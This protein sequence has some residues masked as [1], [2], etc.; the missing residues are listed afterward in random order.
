[1]KDK[2][3]KD[4]KSLILMG[5][6]LCLI[7]ILVIGGVIT[8]NSINT[9][10]NR[11][12]APANANFSDD[13]LY[14][15]VVDAYNEENDASMSY[16]TN[17]TDA[18]L[19][20][21]TKLEC[22]NAGVS[23]VRGLNKLSNLKELDLANNNITYFGGESSTFSS[24]SGLK[25]LV[26]D[27]NKLDGAGQIYMMKGD[28]E[29][30]SLKNNS[31]SS[32]GAWT[33]PSLV[34]MSKLKYLNV[35]NNEFSTMNLTQ[36]TNLEELDA[37][38]NQLK[39]ID[40]SNNNNL[41]P[42][43]VDISGN[44]FE[45]DNYVI[46]DGAAHSGVLVSSVT[47]PSSWTISTS[48]YYNVWRVS[49]TLPD[50][51]VASLSNGPSGYRI[52]PKGIGNATAT[53]TAANNAFT[54]KCNVHS[55]DVA[56]DNE[57]YAT[58]GSKYIWVGSDATKTEEQI[59]SNLS[60]RNNNSNDVEYHFS[61][62]SDVINDEVK[63]SLEYNGNVFAEV[64]VYGGVSTSE[65]YD[66]D[67]DYI[68]F[69][70]EPIK[71]SGDSSTKPVTISKGL[72]VFTSNG[73]V[74]IRNTNAIVKRYVEVDY[75]SSKYD[76][77]VDEDYIW[78]GADNI[79]TANVN[80]TTSKQKCYFIYNNNDAI[81]TLYY[82]KIDSQSIDP[83]SDP[84]IKTWDI[85]GWS[86]DKYDYVESNIEGYDFLVNTK[87]DSSIDSN[88][89]IENIRVTNGTVSRKPA[90]LNYPG[91]YPDDF[92]IKANKDNKIIKE[93]HTVSFYSDKYSSYLNKDYIDV[94]SDEL[95]VDDFSTSV[96]GSVYFKIK[97]NILYVDDDEGEGSTY[98]QWDI[99]SY[100]S[101]KYDLDG[102]YIFVGADD[103]IETITSNITSTNIDIVKNDYNQLEFRHGDEVIKTMDIV[104]CDSS[105]Y[106]LSKKYIFTGTMS[107]EFIKSKIDYDDANSS[108]DIEGDNL[109]L[110]PSN[111]DQPIKTWKLVRCVT[112]GY[113][114]GKSY[115]IQKPT[116][117]ASDIEVINGSYGGVNRGY[118][119]ISYNGET[120]EVPVIN[121]VS[122]NNKYDLEKTFTGNHDSYIYVGT[123][124]LDTSNIRLWFQ[125]YTDVTEQLADTFELN[126]AN[127]EVTATI[128]GEYVYSWKIVKVSSE[129]EMQ[130]GF[131]FVNNEDLDINKMYVTFDIIP[132]GF[133]VVD[134]ALYYGNVYAVPYGS[135]DRWS[136]INIK[137]NKY[138]IGKDT[139][140]INDDEFDIDNIDVQVP[141][142][143][144]YTHSYN[145][146][147]YT[148]T[149]NDGTSSSGYT[150]TYSVENSKFKD[151]NLYKCVVD[152]YNSENS[153]HVGYDEALSTEQLAS[154]TKLSCDGTGKSDSEKVLN[155]TG[156]ELLTGIRS[157][158]LE[159]NHIT[160][161][162][163]SHNTNLS[164]TLKLG[165]NHI[166]SLD[167]S[168][169]PDIQGIEVQSNQLTTLNV[170]NMSNLKTLD[171]S[172]NSLASINL[173]VQDKVKGLQLSANNLE[174]IDVSHYT[175]LESL[176]I[177]GNK[178]TSIDVSN[179]TA[180]Q[181][182][183]VS[184][185]KLTSL[186][187]SHNTALMTDGVSNREVK[188]SGN[189]YHKNIDIDLDVPTEINS[190]VKIPTHLNWPTPTYTLESPSYAT[191]DGNMITAQKVGTFGLTGS[192]EGKYI[193]TM[194]CAADGDYY[195]EV[196][197]EKY[198]L[199]N[200]YL[201]VE[202]SFNISDA[203]ATKGA[204]EAQYDENDSIA[205]VVVGDQV[206]NQW[207]VLSIESDTY[208]I[209]DNKI[210]V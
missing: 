109:V 54:T 72:T 141:S 78:I 86:S 20:S 117:S 46:N 197:P 81:L 155:T 11:A 87:E 83:S 104:H 127:D 62:G 51:D 29:Y 171:A 79:T 181:T 15:C 161:I 108:L 210:Y 80:N 172:S 136:I 209:V 66:V 22:T 75:T 204:A 50:N 130:Q 144:T 88:N 26:L 113:V 156:I 74:H 64:P 208:T 77:P 173:P 189:Q 151:N 188:I 101:D 178:L 17:L 112:D 126:V 71:V 174:S 73:Y 60:I 177:T 6:S 30:L 35:A 129:Y 32:L 52:T 40:L 65:L 179:N 16:N 4:K 100:K 165:Y 93:F 128:G 134:G 148:I 200:H 2:F 115:A 175:A 150:K 158:N 114:I 25:K 167:L 48:P 69:K 195:T 10:S 198:D 92:V 168:H 13:A 28:L 145:N 18:Q 5:Y 90:S 116:Y 96:E 206:I 163:L 182:I 149:V 57:K 142:S 94:K 203:I 27:N 190:P 192:V 34:G 37:S 140:T 21:I 207:D 166:S 7:L 118:I 38:N 76:L 95:S 111:S 39:N 19:Q 143:V 85:I 41:I 97:D 102:N 135:T 184:N 31:A 146:G 55:V 183:D 45:T 53:G 99:V 58:D 68:L 191:I 8:N 84:K 131:I 110:K 24:L 185:N 193:F 12:Y 201:F 44:D 180:L 107:N 49:W 202:G 61:N 106:D 154:L 36:T 137:S 138:N 56:V 103:S 199:G 9:L 153:T 124:Y 119:N 42:S 147:Q 105:Y 67:E 82:K 14:R 3:K 63:L 133:K 162:D 33:D 139:I 170:S 205:K 152:E 160:S 169:N 159:H 186:D 132:F 43:K 120:K 98:K 23:D 70:D 91:V 157:L 121:F 176:R 123:G 194:T 1:M 187:L 122:T 196:N 164:N 89:I 59:L 47:V 125:T